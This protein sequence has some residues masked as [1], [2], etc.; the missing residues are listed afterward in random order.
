MCR[1][2]TAMTNI[3]RIRVPWSG[4]AIVGPGVSTFF[5][6]T[7]SGPGDI[8]TALN[9]FF[10][11]I[12]GQLPTGITF[13]IPSGGDVID[14]A[15]G[16]LTGAWTGGTGSTVTTNGTGSYAA[17]VGA[18][19]AWTTAAIHKKRRVRGTTYIV[20]LL[21]ASFGTNGSL[22]AS[23]STTLTNAA[24]ALQATPNTFPLIWSRP[25]K[26][27]ADGVSSSITG[28]SVPTSVSWLRGRRT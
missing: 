14:D 10:T 8:T 16:N 17:G 26:G 2:V 24:A 4:T 1:T 22:V 11:A 12:R 18:R 19:I 20:P 3:V 6:G 5:Y 23:T 15:T 7:S 13:T 25:T 21:T 9:T 27:T 28:S